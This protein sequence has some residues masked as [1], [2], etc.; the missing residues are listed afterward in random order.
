M[1]KIRDKNDEKQ[2][3]LLKSTVIFIGYELKYREGYRIIK[4]G[5]KEK[6]GAFRHSPSHQK[7]IQNYFFFFS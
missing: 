3:S 1:C 7:S 5:K 4:W 6:E 2:I